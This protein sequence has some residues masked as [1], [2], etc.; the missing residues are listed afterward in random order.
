MKNYYFTFWLSGICIFVFIL[1]N[2][3]N[4]FTD[5]FVL[6]NLAVYNFQIWRF[7]TAIF[8]H[9]SLIHILSNLFALLLFGFILEKKIGSSKFLIVFFLSGI[10]AN[11][12]SVFFYSTS[13]G[14]SGAIMG[15]IGCLTLIDPLMMVW[16]FGFLMPMFIAAIVYIFSDLFGLLNPGDVANIAHLS[17]I[18]IGIIFG[19]F[20]RFFY[21]QEIFRN[22]SVKGEKVNLSDSYI[23]SWEDNYVR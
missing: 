18:C 20:L 22:R 13:L 6:N 9:A 7:V 19:G 21:G 11:V 8:L 16:V 10:V 23:R 2:I 12:V 15:I 1:Q 14:A 5:M 17:G 4:W 3:F